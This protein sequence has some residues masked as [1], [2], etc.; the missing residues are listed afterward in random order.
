MYFRKF[1]EFEDL[2]GIHCKLGIILYM[3]T[4]A[5]LSMIRSVVEARH[6]CRFFLSTVQVC[7]HKVM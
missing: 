5:A 1:V 7:A 3:C 6:T 4:L 2:E